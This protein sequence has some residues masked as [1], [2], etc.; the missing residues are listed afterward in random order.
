MHLVYVYLETSNRK[1]PQFVK[2][3]CAETKVHPKK[4]NGYNLSCRDVP[5]VLHLNCSPPPP[6]VV[7]MHLMQVMVS[8]AVKTSN[9]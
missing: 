8:S 4:I 9:K 6:Q 2:P 5:T 7:V 3:Y 1:A